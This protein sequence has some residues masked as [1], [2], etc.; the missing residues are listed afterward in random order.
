MFRS[1][2]TRQEYDERGSKV[3]QG[4]QS[5]KTLQAEASL[6]SQK[7]VHLHRVRQGRITAEGNDVDHARICHDHVRALCTL[8]S[9]K[10][11]MEGQ[12]RYEWLRGLAQLPQ[13]ADPAWAGIAYRA[14]WRALSMDATMW[15]H[16][17]TPACPWTTWKASWADG[18]VGAVGP[19]KRPSG[20]KELLLRRHQPKP[21]S[22]RA[23]NPHP[24]IRTGPLIEQWRGK[25]DS[26]RSELARP[27]QQDGIEIKRA[28]EEARK[29]VGVCTT[30]QDH[31]D[32]NREEGE[33]V[34][35]SRPR[36]L[37]KLRQWMLDM[38]CL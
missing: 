11:V 31:A 20:W 16:W 7:I 9:S 36:A 25:W 34:A 23:R 2:T 5:K 12:L 21:F 38:F 28:A 14:C 24:R 8:A 15:T 35:G 18:S 26:S 6:E 30:S 27:I 17:E 29:S 33:R 13:T 19:V 1:L 3:V 4:A 22:R 37:G 32:D 10:F